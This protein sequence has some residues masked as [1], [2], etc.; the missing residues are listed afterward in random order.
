MI[1]FGSAKL[2]FKTSSGIALLFWLMDDSLRN[3]SQCIFSSFRSIYSPYDPFLATSLA[4]VQ[5]NGL[6]AAALAGIGSGN[7]AGLDPRLQVRIKTILT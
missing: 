5:A 1:Y 6:S 3:V 2:S 7:H 4:Q